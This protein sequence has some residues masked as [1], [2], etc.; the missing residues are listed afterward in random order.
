MKLNTSATRNSLFILAL[1]LALTG[2]PAV[3]N[4]QDNPAADQKATPVAKF[5]AAKAQA[6][7]TTVDADADAPRQKA[8]K[9]DNSPDAIRKR[10]SGPWPRF[11]TTSESVIKRSPSRLAE[12][13]R[14]W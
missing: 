11:R 5:P 14:L 7:P 6:A 8:A 9:E 12:S 4:A 10:E 3:A 1:L 2:L 13:I